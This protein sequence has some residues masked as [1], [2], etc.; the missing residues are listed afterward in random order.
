M[1]FFIHNIIACIKRRL[2]EHN[3]LWMNLQ[4]LLKPEVIQIY[5]TLSVTVNIKTGIQV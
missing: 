2:F 5:L 1:R 3:E 4:K